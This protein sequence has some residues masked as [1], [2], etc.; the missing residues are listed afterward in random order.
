M[1]LA[2]DKDNV[3]ITT[4]IPPK[5]EGDGTWRLV[6]PIVIQLQLVVFKV[7][8]VAELT[9][10]FASRGFLQKHGQMAKDGILDSGY[11]LRLDPVLGGGSE[12]GLAGILTLLGGGIV[13]QGGVYGRQPNDNVGVVTTH[14][15]LGV[16]A[17]DVKRLAGIAWAVLVVLL[18]D[19]VESCGVRRRAE[20][21]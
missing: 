9:V 5:T 6:Q 18:E 15:G 14:P 3:R 13:A 16:H 21:D 10:R 8:R 12:E 4:S 17:R 11:V 2:L 7:N 1:R 19:L 20:S